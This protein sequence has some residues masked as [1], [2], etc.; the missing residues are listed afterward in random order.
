MICPECQA[1]YREGFRR[2]ADCGVGLIEALPVQPSQTRRADGVLV[3]IWLGDRQSYCVA[4]CSRL[5]NAG[6][7]YHVSQSLKSRIGMIASWRYELSVPSDSAEESKSLLELPDDVVEQSSESAEE[8]EDQALVEYPDLGKSPAEDARIRNSFKTYLDP[9]YPE[10]A[11]TQIW[12]CPSGDHSTMVESS[13]Q[14]NCI[15]ARTE[16]RSDGSTRYFVMAKDADAAR[17][18]VRQILEGLPPS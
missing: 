13:L 10:D 17:E 11:T 2:C 18:I 9:W 8:D 1:E 16:V 7:R 12:S 15:R 6:I 4:L 14:A 3:A 5:K